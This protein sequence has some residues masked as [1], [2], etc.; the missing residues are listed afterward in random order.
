MA[1]EMTGR[2]VDW[3]L[4]QEDFILRNLPGVERGRPGTLKDVARS[5]AI[6]YKTIRNRASAEKWREHLHRRAAEHSAEVVSRIR[7]SEVI[8]EVAVRMRHAEIA[9]RALNKALQRLETLDPSK[10]SARET[11]DLIRLGLSEERKALGLPDYYELRDERRD[12][13]GLESLEARREQQRRLQSLGTMLL[14]YL[15]SSPDHGGR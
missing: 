13:G 11:A 3:Q 2:G 14:E 15:D 10:L 12:F 8:D 1:G 7:T 9:R 4:V 5:W 6:P